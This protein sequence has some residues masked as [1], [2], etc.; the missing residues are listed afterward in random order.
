MA[1]SLY[2]FLIVTSVTPA[3]SPTSGRIEKEIQKIDEEVDK[4]IHKIYGLTN[5]EIKN[6]KGEYKMKYSSRIILALFFFA[7]LIGMIYLFSNKLLL[8][9]LN[10][11]SGSFNVLFSCIVAL[12]TVAYVILTERLVSE[13]KKLRRAQTEPNVSVIIQPREEYIKFID[14]VVQNIGLGPAYDIQFKLEQDFEYWPGKF[15]SQLNFIKNGIKYLAPKQKYQ[16][17]FTSMREDLDKK[18][19]THFTVK[20]IYFQN[21]DKLGK[22]FS[23]SFVIDF[24]ELVGL[25]ELGK[26]P[27][28]KI[29]ENIEH[30]SKNIKRIEGHLS[31][32]S[33]MGSLLSEEEDQR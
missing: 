14:L 30:I 22:K 27:L 17:F 5:D 32:K 4:E 9:F 11:N 25:E 3:T 33:E 24:S 31:Q 12:S 20:V 19:E 13:T 6:C 21:K 7:I 29:A 18:K 15:L 28:Y 2:L 10:S 8:D 16:S 26:P 23:E 1:I